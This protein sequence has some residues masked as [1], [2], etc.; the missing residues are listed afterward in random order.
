MIPELNMLFRRQMRIAV[1]SALQKANLWLDDEPVTIE[2][3]GNWKIQQSPESVSM[4][5]I[6]IRTS[7]ENKS[8]IMQAGIPEFNTATSIDVMCA[9]SSTTAEKAQEDI[10]QLWSQVENILLTDYSIVGS[11]QNVQSV[12][13]KIEIN[14]EG[15]VHIAVVSAVFTYVG[16]EF[17]DSQSTPPLDKTF[18]IKPSPTV[19][20][21]NVDLH[22]DLI[23][24]V[25]KTGDYPESK[26]P[27][28]TI[29]AP[30]THGPD[31]RDEARAD[32]NL[33]G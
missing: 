16:F 12:D 27:T 28:S 8:S 23:N 4:P 14:S 7:M 17:F 24:I 21:D 29:P 11:T 13:S 30:R 1:I 32:I 5:C 25:D 6:F 3:P 15:N 20:L 18:P 10:E 9:I 33:R 22:L 2:S 19:H 26:F 31:G